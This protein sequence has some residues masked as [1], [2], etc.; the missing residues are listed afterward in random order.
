MLLRKN[1]TST[2]CPIAG[3]TLSLLL[4]GVLPIRAEQVA[5][6]VEL[7]DPQ[8][9]DQWVLPPNSGASVSGGELILDTVNRTKNA[10]HHTED[11]SLI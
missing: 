3:L 9:A 10:I 5:L 8:A 11:S 1:W 7:D 2:Y 6:D 4:C